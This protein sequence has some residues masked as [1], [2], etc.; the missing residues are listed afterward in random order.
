MDL[1]YVLYNGF[2]LKYLEFTKFRVFQ[3]ETIIKITISI[4]TSNNLEVEG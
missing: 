1:N 3:D 2:I 4:H